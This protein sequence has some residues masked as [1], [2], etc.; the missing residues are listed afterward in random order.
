MVV[1][2]GGRWPLDLSGADQIQQAQGLNRSGES[3]S[4]EKE[5]VEC[6]VGARES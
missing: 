1:G 5:D 4:L 3:A 2:E 6:R